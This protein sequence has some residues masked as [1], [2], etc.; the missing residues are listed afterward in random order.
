MAHTSRTDRPEN[1]KCG[2][3]RDAGSGGKTHVECPFFASCVRLIEISP[4]VD[5]NENGDA[6]ESG[7]KTVI[8]RFAG[9]YQRGT[10]DGEG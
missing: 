6:V 1:D 5:A 10:S 3:G 2:P 4:A 9:A 7:E 8:C